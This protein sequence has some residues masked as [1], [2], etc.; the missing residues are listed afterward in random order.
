MYTTRLQF[1]PLMTP[2]ETNYPTKVPVVED[3]FFAVYHWVPVYETRNLWL[4]ITA[5]KY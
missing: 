1:L 5:L 4:P 3:R 2:A